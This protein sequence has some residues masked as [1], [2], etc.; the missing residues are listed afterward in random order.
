MLKLIEA[1][2]LANYR[3]Q[4]QFSDGRSG[5]ADLTELVT[6]Q[7]APAFA[8]LREPGVFAQCR[9]EQGVLNWTSA[10]DL[11]PEYLY[12]LAFRNDSSLTSQFRTWGYL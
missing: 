3:L 10:L 11:A 7:E 8:G 5:M 1:K 12:F 2:P 6:A 4:L 9:I